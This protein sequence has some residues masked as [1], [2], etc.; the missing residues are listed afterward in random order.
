MREQAMGMQWTERE[1]RQAMK[2]DRIQ[3]YVKDADGT[4]VVKRTQDEQVTDPD[5]KK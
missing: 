4:I 1:A 2:E 3:S 5:W